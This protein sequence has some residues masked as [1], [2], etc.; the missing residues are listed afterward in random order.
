VE[1]L[2]EVPDVPEVPEV[3]GSGGAISPHRGLFPV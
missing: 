1:Q 2:P 3:P